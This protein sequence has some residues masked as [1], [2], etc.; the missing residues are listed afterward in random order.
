MKV[1]IIIYS[2]YGHV[3]TMARAVKEG[4]ERAGIASQVDIL[5]VPE[6]LSDEILEVL[7]A[8]PKATDIPVASSK[9]LLEYDAY[10]FG[11]A[12]RFG[13]AAAQLYSYWDTTGGIWAKGK[14][15][16]K[17]AGVFVS[18]GTPGG[19]QEAAIRNFL[20]YFVHHGIVYIPFGYATAFPLLS[21]MD[22]VHGGSPYGAGTYAATDGSRQPTELELNMAALQGES[23]VKQGIKFVETLRENSKPIAPKEEEVEVVAEPEDKKPKDV[24]KPAPATATPAARANQS[25][26]S[27]EPKDKTSCSKCSIM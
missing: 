17:P 6:T 22:E 19:G 27:P 1:A 16:G 20:E 18:G 12:I 7:H 8:P 25:S 23:F 21:N 14:L 13:H 26:A 11:T 5:Q 24:K 2:T 4:A 10:I 9:K 15:H 3:V